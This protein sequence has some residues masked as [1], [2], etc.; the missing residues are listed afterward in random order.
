MMEWITPKTMCVK[1]FNLRANGYSCLGDWLK[2]PTNVYI[3]RDM[4][5]FIPG[6][7]ESKWHNPFKIKDYGLTKSIQHYEEYIR[8]TPELMQAIPGLAGLSLGCWC[9]KG[10][11]HGQI[12]IKLFKEL[13]TAKDM[14]LVEAVE[15]YENYQEGIKRLIVETIMSL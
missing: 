10:V 5:H 2:E 13:S 14:E 15:Q 4:T 6:A 12:L 1:L 9:I 3:G 11:C 7:V 8:Q